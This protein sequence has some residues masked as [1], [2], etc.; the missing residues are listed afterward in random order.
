MTNVFRSALSISLIIVA[1]IGC[2]WRAGTN[3]EPVPEPVVES[4]PAASGTPDASGGESHFA[5][6]EPLIADLYKQHDAE[7]GP[8][9]ER[10]RA[11]VDKYFAKPLA[12]M[13]WKDQQTPP[14]EMG[15]LDFDPLYDGQD[16]SVKKFSIGT[17]TV[18]GDKANVR[19]SFENY[20]E[21]KALTYQIV[22]QGDSYKIADIKYSSGFTLLGV[23]RENLKAE[24]P[25]EPSTNGE[26]EGR[27]RVGDTT[28]TVEFKNRGFAVKWA[29]GSG[30]EY[31]SFM[32]GTTFASST[33]ESEA[34]KFV[35]DDE[36][37]HTG[38]FIEPTARHSRF[39]GLGKLA[40]RTSKKAG[41]STCLSLTM[42]GLI[43][44]HQRCS[45]LWQLS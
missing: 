32:E 41:L 16:I 22:R 10:K 27:Y 31:F 14:G 19:V 44:E 40:M 35:F 36:N 11:V 39:H 8:F 34:N 1:A 43:N 37:Y 29:K 20:G 30:V 7:K 15:M 38:I 17:A 13:I 23:F 33:V 12:D 18:S 45:V 6:A 42:I 3:G 25:G 21:K 5:A 26:F 2:S 4:T 9:R 24:K 28:C